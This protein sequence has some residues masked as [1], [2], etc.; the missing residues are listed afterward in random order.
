MATKRKVLS[1]G[2]YMRRK[3]QKDAAQ[4]SEGQCV[5]REDEP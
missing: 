5:H 2:N 1:L 3:K 4:A